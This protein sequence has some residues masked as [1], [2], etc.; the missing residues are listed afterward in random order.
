MVLK[1][2]ASVSKNLLEIQIHK[3]QQCLF[4]GLLCFVWIVD[5]LGGVVWLVLVVQAKGYSFST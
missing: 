3:A 2:A 4:F 1:A 5:F